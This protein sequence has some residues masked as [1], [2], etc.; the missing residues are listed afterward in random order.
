MRLLRYDGTN[1]IF[2]I[3][4]FATDEAP[5]YAILSHT[6]GDEEV[7]FREI[8]EGTGKSKLGYEK[9]RFCGTQA[10]RDHL[11]YFWVDTCCINK[12]SST[13]LQEAIICMFRWYRNAVK[14]YVY[15]SDVSR[16]TSDDGEDSSPPLWEGAFRQSRWFTRGWTLQELIAPTLVEFFSKEG[17]Q[18]GDKGSLEEYIRDITGI[19]IAVLRGSRLST[20]GILERMAWADK[21][22]TTRAEDIAYSLLGIFDVQIP[23]LYG[24]GRYKALKRLHEEIYNDSK[25]ALPHQISPPLPTLEN[26][27]DARDTV[28]DHAAHREAALRYPIDGDSWPPDGKRAGIAALS[29]RLLSALIIDGESRAEEAELYQVLRR[30][31]SVEATALQTS[32]R[33]QF[34]SYPSDLRAAHSRSSQALAR[35]RDCACPSTS[36]RNS[37]RIWKFGLSHDYKSHHLPG[38]ALYSSGYHSWSY[39]V[40]AQLFPFLNKTVELTLGATTAAGVW[41]MAPPVRLRGTV[42]R[43]DSPI[44]SLFDDI[45]QACLARRLVSSEGTGTVIGRRDDVG[46]YG[47]IWNGCEGAHEMLLQAVPYIRNAIADGHASGSDLDEG[48]HSF[49]FVGHVT[50]SSP[51]HYLPASRKYC[52]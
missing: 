16:S 13:E 23:L 33:H 34:L 40:S 49:L 5:P 31:Q 4:D 19:P 39:S 30:L 37:R 42:R 6:W 1:G 3:E 35:L 52:P 38:C 14:C 26:T 12:S 18:L 20:F 17:V 7:T 8:T 11:Q 24:E 21:R 32:I 29:N 47:W 28:I 43:V 48:G 36:G 51:V 9:I 50:K 44:F 45:A 27:R 2:L 46:G 22:N 10:E 15:L 41:W 25:A